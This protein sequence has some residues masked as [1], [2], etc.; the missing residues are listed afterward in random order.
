MGLEVYQEL[1]DF[2]QVLEVKNEHR[3]I[4]TLK[5]LGRMLHCMALK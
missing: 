5:R 4:F 2:I 1:V 3:H